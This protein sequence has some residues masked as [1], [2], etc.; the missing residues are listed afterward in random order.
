MHAVVEVIP[1]LL[2]VSMI[3]FF[4]G[5]VAF[6]VPVN[7]GIMILCAFLLAVVTLVY[8]GLTVFPL[9]CYDTPYHTPLSSGIWY[10]PVQ[11]R[12]GRSTSTF[13]LSMVEVMFRAAG[14]KSEQRDVR[15]Y[16][17]LCWTVR[18]LADDEQLEPFIE[19]IP[20]ALWSS[21]GRRNGY[22]EHLKVLLH[23]PQVQLLRR[24]EHFLRGCDTDLLSPETQF[25]RRVTALKALWA[26]ATIPGQDGLFLEAL[27]PFD[28]TL[29]W[30]TRAQ[31][32]EDHYQLSTRTVM[33]LNVLLSIG[34][35]IHD[36]TRSLGMDKTF[37]PTYDILTQ[38]G[39][40]IFKLDRLPRHVWQ[41]SA[42]CEARDNLIDLKENPPSDALVSSSWVQQCLDTLASVRQALLALE[43]QTFVSFMIDAAA[44]E[45][46]PYEFEA[47][48]AAFSFDEAS[49]SAD[50]A[51]TFSTAFDSVVSVQSRR[52]SYSTHA[53]EILTILLSVCAS[54]M[55][56]DPTYFPINLTS[57]LTTQKLSGSLVLQKCNTLWLYG[58]L[59][60]ELF[61]KAHASPLLSGPV[62][63]AMWEIACLMANQ[64]LNSWNYRSNPL[65]SIRALQAVRSVAG[66]RAS[67]ST[68]ALIQTNVLNAM[69]PMLHDFD[70]LESLNMVSIHPI[71]SK[72]H[73]NPFSAS[74]ENVEPV[75]TDVP[76]LSILSMRILILADFI[77]E[78]AGDQLVYNPV[79][80]ANIL[81][82]FVPCAPG[83]QAEH[84][85]HFARSWSAVLS[86]RSSPLI[87]ETLV[88]G[89]ILSAYWEGPKLWSVDAA[90]YRWLDDPLAVQIFTESLTAYLDRMTGQ[91][92]LVQRLAMIKN[93]SQ[94]Y[95]RVKVELG[96]TN[97]RRVKVAIIFD[98]AGARF[99]LQ[100]R[101]N[102]CGSKTY[103]RRC[104]GGYGKWN[105]LRSGGE[106]E[107][108]K[109]NTRGRHRVKR[110][111]RRRIHPIM[112]AV[113]PY[114]EMPSF[115][116][117][118][119]AIT[120][121]SRTRA[122]DG[123]RHTISERMTITQ[124]LLFS[125]SFSMAFGA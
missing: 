43:H 72:D 48:R 69:S 61:T 122:T 60:A 102:A 6:L 42:D 4:A 97:K 124:R 10:L 73:D 62:V 58:C 123:P 49:V 114:W 25:R 20:D 52:S 87:L 80:T 120:V 44:Q 17:A 47:T 67:T 37:Q 74:N 77:N 83:V 76:T 41:S 59:T 115:S 81:T 109:S 118:P 117:L 64:Y 85:V 71:L 99:L 121:D 113:L 90:K 31:S 14:Q 54:G 100:L 112:V 39:Q 21:H 45:S 8:T 107:I 75:S 34:G 22:N 110:R 65:V 28:G 51:D 5:L 84:Q 105:G 1:L 3:V 13:D 91:S 93:C 104:A 78:C 2:H 88:K 66:S 15:D 23:D 86:H 12:V 82:N 36:V 96:S 89:K 30:R 70:N 103:G 116:L 46:W 57:Y 92:K 95:V 7:T 55:R 9:L 27:E 38:L 26:I 111:Q 16:R 40:I 11:D 63:D 101:G 35:Y 98:F 53:D 29:L 94:K 106:F 18:S 19:G 108:I 32:K 24:I 33:D 68:I 50:M 56:D 79:E 125:P 119:S